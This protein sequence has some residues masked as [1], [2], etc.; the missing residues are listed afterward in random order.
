MFH[1]VK[2]KHKPSPGVAALL[3][4]Q[5]CQKQTQQFQGKG[6]CWLRMEV[7]RKTSRLDP[8]CLPNICEGKTQSYPGVCVCA[9]AGCSRALQPPKNIRIHSNPGFPP[10]QTE[11]TGP[12]WDSSGCK[13]SSG[14][15]SP[16]AFHPLDHCHPSEKS[17][18]FLFAFTPHSPEEHEAGTP[19]QDE[20]G[21]SPD[22]KIPQR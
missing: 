22:C 18:Y 7:P 9:S 8:C 2:R 19:Q 5:A 12:G 6:K 13:V 11:G 16:S 4:S 21:I 14:V 20:I 10:P 17:P 3:L 1:V 15:V